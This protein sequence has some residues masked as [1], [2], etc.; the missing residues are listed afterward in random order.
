MNLPVLT[1]N[2]CGASLE[3]SAEAESVTCSSCSA[4]LQVHRSGDAAYTE[5]LD[6]QQE[7]TDQVVDDVE[8]MKLRLDLGELDREWMERHVGE[9][10][11]LPVAG[12]TVF[13]VV[14]FGIAGLLSLGAGV[15]IVT[16]RPEWAGLFLLLG[17]FLTIGSVVELQRISRRNQAYSQA[18]QNYEAKR[19]AILREIDAVKGTA[20]QANGN[21]RSG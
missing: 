13:G 3:V 4:Q 11:S 19:R 20:N 15:A 18:K 6:T 2:Q 21:H 12:M 10:G 14:G 7:Q 16:R 17:G 5:V 8:T 9:S 1:C